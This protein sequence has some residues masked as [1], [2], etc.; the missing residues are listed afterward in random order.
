[1]DVIIKKEGFEVV[2]ENI[3]AREKTSRFFRALKKYASGSLQFTLDQNATIEIKE[4]NFSQYVKANET[5]TI[6]VRANRRIKVNFKNEIFGIDKSED[7]LVPE[8]NIVSKA[9]KLNP[10]K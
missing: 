1:M 3:V 8:G 7:F 2:S 10:G 5:I 6:P 4:I 9:I